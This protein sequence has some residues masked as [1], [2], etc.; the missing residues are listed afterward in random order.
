MNVNE[1]LL[2][3]YVV[4]GNFVELESK[5]PKIAIV[6]YNHWISRS[7][8]TMDL[9]CYPTVTFPSLLFIV[10]KVHPTLKD[11]FC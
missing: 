11:V 3:V 1:S 7:V 9:S 8:F 2:S 10:Y 6:K 5:L 4:T